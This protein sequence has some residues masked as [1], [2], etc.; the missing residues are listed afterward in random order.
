MRSNNRSKR[1]GLP[2]GRPSRRDCGWTW[3]NQGESERFVA[4]EVVPDSAPT[5]ETQQGFVV[6]LDSLRD[7]VVLLHGNVCLFDRSVSLGLEKVNL[8]GLS[9]SFPVGSQNVQKRV[10]EVRIRDVE[11]GAIADRLLHSIHQITKRLERPLDRDREA[12]PDSWL[13]DSDVNDLR[14]QSPQDRPF[15]GSPKLWHVAQEPS[16]SGLLDFEGWPRSDVFRQKATFHNES[17][18]YVPVERPDVTLAFSLF[19]S[20]DKGRESLA[21]R[22][23]TASLRGLSHG[24]AKPP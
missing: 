18:G 17:A 16:T 24:A 15:A 21:Q 7:R 22:D 14:L 9:R 3:L 10:H 11:V 19:R 6:P 1:S 12:G 13:C 5:G 4:S 8:F 2:A 23:P 20:K